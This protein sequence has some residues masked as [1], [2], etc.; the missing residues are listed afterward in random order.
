MFKSNN[1]QYNCNE[2]PILNE[3]KRN[4]DNEFDL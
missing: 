2:P 1:E 3:I 4:F